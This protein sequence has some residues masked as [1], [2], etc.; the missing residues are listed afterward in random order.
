VPGKWRIGAA[1]GLSFF[2][3]EAMMKSR[4][5][6]TPVGKLR[7]KYNA[8]KH[9][10]FSS[11]VLLESE[12]QSEFD[13]L[14]EG[15]RRYFR[16]KGTLEEILVE[17]L[18]TLIWRYRRLLT[19]EVA[20]IRI[21]I[22]FPCRSKEHQS[23]RV[24][25]IV[26]TVDGQVH[27]NLM[28]G[29]ADP[30]IREKCLALLRD[31][32]TGIDTGGFDTN[33]DSAILTKLCQDR[34]NERGRLT[35]YGRYRIWLSK[36]SCSEEER[37]KTGSASPEQCKRS[38]LEEVDEEIRRLERDKSI[39]SERGR[40]EAIRQYVPDSS[41]PDRLLRYEASL[42]RSFDRTL[43]QLERLQRMRLGQPV[44]PKL[45]VRHSVS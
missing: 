32:K 30:E 41:Q 31:L 35:L 34:T 24:V 33:R 27:G 20:E 13:S 19:A 15:L 23:T 36:A 5:P 10:I 2:F 7:S 8:T 21:G 44:L 45:E 9:G 42:E 38:F 6:R 14:L 37:Q 12:S 11:V 40:L 4:G 3:L 1:P 22:A 39:E 26:E 17:K 43:S 28:Q 25:T 18:A 16:P 29:I